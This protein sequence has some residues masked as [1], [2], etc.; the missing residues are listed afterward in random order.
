MSSPLVPTAITTAL[1]TRLRGAI[2]AAGCASNVG[3]TVQV[4]R[5]KAGAV[6][7]PC[8]YVTP[9]RGTETRIYGAVQRTRAYEVR[10][11]AD[12][13]AH[14]ALSDCD[15]VDQI[16]FD[17]RRILEEGAAL[18]GVQDLRYVAD[19]PGYRED[20]GTLVGALIEYE[21]DYIIDLTDPT[22]P[23]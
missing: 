10:A 19:S 20:G 16:I 12:L 3:A 18:A 21:V 13:N 23:L 1:T 7:A 6:E 17:V 4:G 22:T 2:T 15:L 14:P 9:G 8:C 11:F 5:V